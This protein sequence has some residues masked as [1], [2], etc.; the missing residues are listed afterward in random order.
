MTGMREVEN[1]LITEKEISDKVK[2]L[3]AVISHDYRGKEILMVGVLKGAIVFMADLMRRIVGSVSID[4][5]AVS[6]YGAATKSSGVV[7]ILKDLDKSISGKNVIIVE[8]IVD[9]GLTLSFLKKNLEQRGP[10]SVKIVTLLDKPDRRKIDIDV[11]Y[12]GFQIPDL[13]VVGYG[14]DYDEKH[15]NLPYI[16]VLK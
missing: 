6:S 3:A 12:C 5:M 4:F 2:E 15:R 9:T 7:K 10:E 14:L 1:I 13:F 8:D 16:A 11:Q